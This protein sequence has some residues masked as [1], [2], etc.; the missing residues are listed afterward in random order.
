MKLKIRFRCY[1]CLLVMHFQ[2][3]SSNNIA[4]STTPTIFVSNTHQISTVLKCV[5]NLMFSN[6]ML[7]MKHYA[8]YQCE[9]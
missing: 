3:L 5:A 9:F 8:N 1:A 2:L 7:L 6:I 4:F